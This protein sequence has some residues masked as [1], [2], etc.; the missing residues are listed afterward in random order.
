MIDNRAGES[1]TCTLEE[2]GPFGHLAMTAHGWT[3]KRAMTRSME[4]MANQ[5]LPALARATA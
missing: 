1:R 5:V 4:L 2:V 3:D